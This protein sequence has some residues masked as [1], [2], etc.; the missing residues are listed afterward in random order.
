MNEQTVKCPICGEPYNDYRA[1]LSL[2]REETLSN[3]DWVKWAEA[4][5]LKEISK[6][7]R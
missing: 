6:P 2:E 4:L 7:S 5:P 1:M 3:K